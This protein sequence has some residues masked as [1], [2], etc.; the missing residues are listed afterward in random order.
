MHVFVN[1]LVGRDS[2]YPY[3]ATVPPSTDPSADCLS[4]AFD[5]AFALHLSPHILRNV[6]RVLAHAG[7]SAATIAQYLELIHDV[8]ELSGGAVTEPPR[9]AFASRDHEDNLILDLVAEVGA[10]LLV[11]DD[12]DLTPLSPW[13][14]TP[15]LRPHEFVRRVIADRRHLSG[16]TSARGE[17][18]P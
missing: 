10:D 8:V 3:L 12:A 15:I 1:A 18:D 7:L 5:G 6:A 16:R 2:T 9:V 11:S 4:I 17:M 14:G 13:H